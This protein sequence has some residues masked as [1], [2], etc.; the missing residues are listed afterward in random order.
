[1]VGNDCE[2][3]LS[4][5]LAEINFLFP[6]PNSYFEELFFGDYTTEN[7]QTQ[8]TW[9]SRIQFYYHIQAIQ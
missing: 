9:I 4:D 5:F 1:M 3:G 7:S 8:S 2:N 6:Y